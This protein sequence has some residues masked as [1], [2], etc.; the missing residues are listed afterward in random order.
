M[1]EIAGDRWADREKLGLTKEFVQA[2]LLEQLHVFQQKNVDF[3]I[4]EYFEFIDEMEWAIEVLKKNTS[5]PVVAS[6]CIGKWG[7]EGGR[8]PAECAVRMVKAGAEVVGVNC[9]FGPMEAL[10]LMRGGLDVAGF[11]NIYIIV[12][13]LVYHTPGADQNGFIDLPEFY[14]ALEPRTAP[15][16]EIAW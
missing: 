6:M 9:H 12:Q 1:S 3:I 14:F 5:M 7:D 15:R 2:Q 16:G 11:K 8:T 4:A 10:S 13:P